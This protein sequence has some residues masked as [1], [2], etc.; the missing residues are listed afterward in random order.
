MGILP[1]IQAYFKTHRPNSPGG[2]VFFPKPNIAA[3]TPAVLLKVA[4]HIP[5]APTTYPVSPR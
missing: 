4:S 1:K 5:V 2:I 3:S